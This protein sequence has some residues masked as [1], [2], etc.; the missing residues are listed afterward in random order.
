MTYAKFQQVAAV[1]LVGNATG[2]LANA[3][4]ITLGTSLTFSGS[5]V[6]TIQGIRTADSPTFSGLTTS[7]TGLVYNTITSTTTGSSN[8][9]GLNLVRGDQANGFAQTHY[10]TTTTDTWVTGLRSG[11]AKFYIRDVVNSVNTLVITGGSIPSWQV[12]GLFNATTATVGSIAYNVFSNTDNTNA[13]SSCMV[14]SVVG[15]GSAGDPTIGLTVSGVTDWFIG[16][17]NSVSDQ[18]CIGTGQT[19]G[20][21]NWFSITTAGA[22]TM[23]GPVTIGSSVVA[24]S[25][26]ISSAT[27]ASNTA[28]LVLNR[29]DLAN[30]LNRVLYKTGGTSKW[31][32]GSRSAS[33]NLL[34]YDETNSKALLTFTAGASG[35]TPSLLAAL[36]QDATTYWSFSNENNTSSA[37]AKLDIRVGGA[38][39]ADPFLVFDITGVGGW[40][41]GLDNSDSDKLKFDYGGPPTPGSATKLVIDTSGNLYPGTDNSF[42]LGKSGNRWSQLWAGTTTINTSD[43]STKNSINKTRLGLDFINKLIPREFKFNARKRVHHGLVAQEVKRVLEDLNIDSNDFAGYVDPKI[44]NQKDESPCGLRYSEF[45]APLILAVQELSEKINN[46]QLKGF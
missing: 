1:S 46:M 9:G 10:K 45:I 31:G 29:F 15:G 24:N 16:L 28:D 14:Q 20:T 23:Y 44:E 43:A 13:A 34:I 36:A 27:G 32:V 25:L 30:G 33:D 8:E 6:N 18:F 37:N 11:D 7:S 26:T 42:T 35:T 4:G 40:S 21:N 17:D 41:V 19:P 2:S 38:S 39:A 12:T 3:T 5:T 22:A